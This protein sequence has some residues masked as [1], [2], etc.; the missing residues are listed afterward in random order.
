MNYKSITRSI[1][2][3]KRRFLLVPQFGTFIDFFSKIR[4]R[5]HGF[6]KP[7]FWAIS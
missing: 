1:Y 2:S 5:E 3:A 7:W 4:V 6:R